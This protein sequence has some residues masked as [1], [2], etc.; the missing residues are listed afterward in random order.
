M[1][2]ITY[3]KCTLYLFT[4]W[5][6][7]YSAINQL[8]ST[9]IL[10]Q[11]YYE[12]LFYSSLKA[13]GTGT[14][15]TIRLLISSFICLVCIFKVVTWSECVQ[16]VHIIR[17]HHFKAKVSLLRCS[18]LLVILKHDK[19]P[20]HVQW[21]VSVSISILWL[22]QLQLQQRKRET[23]LSFLLSSQSCKTDPELTL[24]LS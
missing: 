1:T 17:L 14:I 23:Q 6:M 18:R 4:G 24:V 15:I 8:D 16:I 19:L 22:H 2:W 5:K 13:K 3:S 21:D 7:L 11:K 10:I 9:S 12:N 20:Q